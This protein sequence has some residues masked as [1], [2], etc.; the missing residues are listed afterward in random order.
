[1][2][3]TFDEIWM[4]STEILAEKSTCLRQ[5]VGCYIVKDNR[6][7]AVGYNGMPSGDPNCCD[8]GICE[9]TAREDEDYKPCVHAEQNAICFAATS[10]I[11]I[12]GST[13]YIT[14]QPCTTCAKMLVQSK[15][16]RAVIRQAVGTKPN[17]DGME[18]LIKHHVDVFEMDN[19]S[20]LRLFKL[21]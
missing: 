18:Y 20:N 8:T 2:R 21:N 12:A 7:I 4:R 16:S 5:K 6:P 14:A 10:S 11:S 19:N 1:M 17:K 15:V 9:K 3:P 13:V